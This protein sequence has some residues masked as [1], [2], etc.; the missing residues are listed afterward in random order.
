MVVGT[1]AYMAP[2]QLRGETAD[3]RSDIWALGVMLY[4]M[5]S[6]A[7]P[8]QGETGFALTSAILKEAP[9]PLPAAVPAE[10]GATIARCLEKEAGRRYQQAGEV[11]AALDA[12]Q[13]GTAASWGAWRYRLARRRWLALPAGAP[14]GRRHARRAHRARPTSAA[15]GRGWPAVL[16]RRSGWPCCRSR[17]GP[18]TPSRSTS[19]TA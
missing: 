15:C 19:A 7:R 18:A 13:A 3:A 11:R 4:E 6:G 16:P 1:L 9:P 14:G 10:V 2:E 8:F 17:T 12:T 5:V